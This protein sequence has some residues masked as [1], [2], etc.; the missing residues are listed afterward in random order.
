MDTPRRRATATATGRRR[1]GVEAILTAAETL[2]AERGYNAVP[3]SAIAARA[4]VSKANVFHHFRTKD[5]LYLA[6]LRRACEAGS[7]IWR[8]RM[9][10]ADSFREG[11]RH[12]ARAHLNHLLAQGDVSR[13]ILR[14]V[15]ENGPRRGPELAEQVFGEDFDGFVQII[16]EGQR[17]GDLRRDADPS[18]VAALLL[19]ADVFFFLA[20]SVMI[21]MR[22]AAFAADPERYSALLSDY[23]LNGLEPHVNLEARTGS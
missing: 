16:R 5:R 4:G 11:I 12:A 8:E 1:S 13:L 14:E 22:S 7:E 3:V 10:G 15:I 19:G 20:H 23:L 9:A 6:V 2:F 21:H 18:V 17:R